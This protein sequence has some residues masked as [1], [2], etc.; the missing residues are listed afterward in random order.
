VRSFMA[1]RYKRKEAADAT[2]EQLVI[3]NSEECG[4]AVDVRE[5]LKDGWVCAV[6]Q[7]K[8]TSKTRMS[9]LEVVH[10]TD[11]AIA[12]AWHQKRKITFTLVSEVM[13][14]GSRTGDRYVDKSTKKLAPIEGDDGAKSAPAKSATGKSTPDKS[15]PAKSATGSSAPAKRGPDKDFDESESAHSVES[16]D[17]S[18]LRPVFGLVR[19]SELVYKL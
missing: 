19:L 3:I 5:L 10:V 9:K 6:G 11:E 13:M 8:F 1:Q 15:A 7:V 18:I 2:L 12:D 17:E 4:N 16:F 14:R